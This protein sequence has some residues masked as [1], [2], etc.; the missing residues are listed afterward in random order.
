MLSRR[1]SWLT[2]PR[3]PRLLRLLLLLHWRL[4]PGLLLLLWRCL[5][6]GLLLLLWRRSLLLL[7]LSGRLSR[8]LLWLYLC[9]Y[10][11]SNGF[12]NNVSHHR[13][14]PLHGRG[15]G[16]GRCL[17]HL[18]GLCSHIGSRTHSIAGEFRQGTKSERHFSTVMIL[19]TTT[20]INDLTLRH[21]I[22][23]FGG[24]LV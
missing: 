2:R 16:R 8:R 5:W 23:Q 17:G 10:S 12:R 21:F 24:L 20:I 22:D 11:L 4:R 1:L 13:G 14:S 3:R 9:R 15:C 19:T 6:P 7:S 18:G